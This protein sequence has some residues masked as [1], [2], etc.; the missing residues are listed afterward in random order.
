MS[1]RRSD[2]ILCRQNLNAKHC[3]WTE[4]EA[5]GIHVCP[6]KKTWKPEISI[7]EPTVE[8]RITALE[9]GI[10]DIFERLD[11]I[12]RRIERITPHG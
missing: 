3:G 10:D 8:D 5:S 11:E 4:A 2:G 1:R 12:E 9:D 7:R 6:H